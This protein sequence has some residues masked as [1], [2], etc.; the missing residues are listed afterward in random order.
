MTMESYGQKRLG[1]LYDAI[2]QLLASRADRSIMKAELSKLEERFGNKVVEWML[3]VIRDDMQ[4]ITPREE[5]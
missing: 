3:G 4:T 1:E 5:E 2:V